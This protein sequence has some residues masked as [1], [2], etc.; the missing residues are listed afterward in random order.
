MCSVVQGKDMKSPCLLYIKEHNHPISDSE[1]KG[2]GES[3][4]DIIYLLNDW[5]SVHN[6]DVSPA[7][8]NSLYHAMCYISKFSDV[9]FLEFIRDI[10]HLKDKRKQAAEKSKEKN[11]EQSNRLNIQ[12]DNISNKYNNDIE[13]WEKTKRNGGS[14]FKAMEIRMNIIQRHCTLP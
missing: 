14:D 5:K 11:Y 9:K 1:K 13:D 3:M 7:V 10:D 12:A 4:K 2:F 8:V 6:I